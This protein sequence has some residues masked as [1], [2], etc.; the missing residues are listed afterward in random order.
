MRERGGGDGDCMHVL[1]TILLSKS[2]GIDN[3]CVDFCLEVI[4]LASVTV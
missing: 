3:V 4:V 1:T 2:G